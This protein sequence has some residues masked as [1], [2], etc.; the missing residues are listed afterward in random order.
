MT[1]LVM[2]FQYSP[3]IAFFLAAGLYT[4]L[5]QEIQSFHHLFRTIGQ[6]SEHNSITCYSSSDTN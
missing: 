2:G 1:H 6:L 5:H 4:K 3:T